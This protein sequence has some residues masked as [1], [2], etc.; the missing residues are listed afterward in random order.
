[1]HRALDASQHNTER[2]VH[3]IRGQRHEWHI[4][5]LLSLASVV[6]PGRQAQLDAVHGA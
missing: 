3:E 4:I 1:L 5:A 6:Q 2:N